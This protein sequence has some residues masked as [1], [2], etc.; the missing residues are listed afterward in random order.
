VSWAN[1]TFFT[2]GQHILWVFGYAGCG[3]SA[4]AQTVGDR[5]AEDR[6]LGAAF[7]FFRGT[8]ERSKMSKFAHTLAY[9]IAA[10]IPRTAEHI[11]AALRAHPALLNPTTSLIA[12]LRYLVYDP[13]RAVSAKWYRLSGVWKPFVVVIDGLDECED[14]ED[15]TAFIKDLISLFERK[16]GIPLRF[17]IT[18]RV[19]DHL[20]QQLHSSPQV[21]L[22]DLVE[23]TSHGDI[24]AALDAAIQDASGGRVLDACG[25]EWLSQS[26]K[27]RLIKHIGKSFIF[28]TTIVK[29]LFASSFTDGLTPASRL[30]MVLDM[31][32]GYGAGGPRFDEL[33]TSILESSQ[34]L[35]HF[36]DIVST[37]A[38]SRTALSIAEIAN[39][40]DITIAGVAMVLVSLHS[41]IQ[42]PGD[43]RAPVTLWHTSLRDFLTSEARSGT[44]H[45]SPS[46]HRR[47]TYRC[48]SLS[49]PCTAPRLSSAS[50]YP[51]RY[52][53]HHW[54]QFLSTIKNDFNTLQYEI[55]QVVAHLEGTFP[56]AFHTV[57]ATYFHLDLQLC[58]GLYPG[59]SS[60]ASLVCR[61][62]PQTRG[63]A[64]VIVK[65]FDAVLAGDG[66]FQVNLLAH[67]R[68]SR[69]SFFDVAHHLEIVM[70]GIPLLVRRSVRFNGALLLDDSEQYLLA[71]WTNHL[72]LAIQADP[73]HPAFNG[74]AP[75][76][77]FPGEEAPGLSPL[78]LGS[79]SRALGIPNRRVLNPWTVETIQAAE[80]NLAFAK[81]VVENTIG[82]KVRANCLGLVWDSLLT[83]CSARILR[84]DG[85]GIDL[86]M[87]K[88]LHLYR[89]VATSHHYSL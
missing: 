11:E 80:S 13:I 53:T 69:P 61:L 46:L 23:H 74:T 52:A 18:S 5:L 2:E 31:D 27:E 77:V 75:E 24:E 34:S 38:L 85:F 78:N 8:G 68:Q 73:Q 33:Y 81:G 1:S 60:V 57:A 70:R 9:Q 64:E 58:R 35:L 51:S 29:V 39:L 45:A 32:P 62:F 72:A 44:F 84:V 65:I 28:M 25:K 41:I 30:P 21:R 89:S 56:A 71:S 26:D 48:I 82:R 42:V 43:D 67:M 79:E 20:H 50:E 17:L 36:H 63:Q 76:R 3:K 66:A 49:A 40:L 59:A 37:I 4:I 6:R 12:Q 16:P 87:S 88:T 22:L 19:E 7:F 83:V 86:L 47:L 55:D 14:K 15:T 10:T 54:K